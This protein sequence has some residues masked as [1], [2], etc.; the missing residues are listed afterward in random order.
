MKYRDEAGRPRERRQ[1]YA[2]DYARYLFSKRHKPQ[3]WGFHPYNDMYRYALR[4]NATTAPTSEYYYNLFNGPG[5]GTP[6]IWITAVGS[7]YHRPCD[8]LSTDF[9]ARNCTAKNP[10]ESP[11]AMRD[12]DLLVGMER[13]KEGVRKL[14]RRIGTSRLGATNAAGARLARLYYHRLQ[15]VKDAETFYGGPRTVLGPGCCDRKDWGLV[16]AQNDNG[17]PGGLAL[18]S[19]RRRAAIPPKATGLRDTNAA[20][21]TAS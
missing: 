16:G 19:F 11:I 7:Y 4:P 5:Y 6:K 8:T 14:L 1:N 15:L 21:R 17:Y 18:T 20:S 2:R 12:Q 13:Q 9:Q 3:V 10:D